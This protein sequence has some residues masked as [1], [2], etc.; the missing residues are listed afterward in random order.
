MLGYWS[1]VYRLLTSDFRLPSS[2]FHLPPS[3]FGFRHKFLSPFL[4][5]RQKCRQN[6]IQFLFLSWAIGLRSSDFRLLTFAFRLPSSVFHLPPSVFVFR[7]KFLSP[8]LQKRQKCRQN[9]I[10]FL[11]LSSIKMLGYWSSVFGLPTSV[12]HL[13]SSAFRLRF[14]T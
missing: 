1:T 3:V 7:H 12:F 13:P 11:F 10:Q 9:P 14:P 8:F 4:Q 5:K 2:V 6:P